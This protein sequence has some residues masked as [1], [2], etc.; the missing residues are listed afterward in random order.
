MREHE[1]ANGASSVDERKTLLYLVGSGLAYNIVEGLL[2]IWA[3]ILAH[4]I[5]LVGFGLDSGVEAL[6]SMAALRFLRGQMDAKAE[7]KLSRLI[8]WTFLALSAYILVQSVWDF[9]GGR[10]VRPS[11]LGFTIT[12]IS[13]ILMPVIGFWKLH[14]ARCLESAGLQAE[15]KETIACSLLSLLAVLGTGIRLLGGPSWVDAAAAILMVPWLLHEGWEGI[16]GS[17]ESGQRS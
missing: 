1:H 6:A 10:I 8:G 15:A 16:R 12:T 11:P 3:G 9:I 4:S 17:A 5:V 7:A 2:C 14:L 13:L